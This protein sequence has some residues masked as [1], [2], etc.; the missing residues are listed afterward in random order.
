MICTTEKKIDNLKYACINFQ[1]L[2]IKHSEF[3]TF[4][5]DLDASSIIGVTET[6]LDDSYDDNNWVIN[7]DVYNIFRCD[8]DK[9]LGLELALLQ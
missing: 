3:K 9:F 4:V 2:P 8:R 7:K 1:N 5:K 6:W